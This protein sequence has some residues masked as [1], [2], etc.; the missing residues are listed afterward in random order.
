MEALLKIGITGARNIISD[1]YS[2]K[3]DYLWIDDWFTSL[4]VI[5]VTS[6]I[7]LMVYFN[8]KYRK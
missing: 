6:L 8:C 1:Y 5:G 4:T 2:Y 3:L 7:A